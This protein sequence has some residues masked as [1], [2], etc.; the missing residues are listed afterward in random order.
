MSTLQILIKGWRY[1]GEA[2]PGKTDFPLYITEHTDNTLYSSHQS[3]LCPHP[4]HHWYWG[5]QRCFDWLLPP[6]GYCAGYWSGEVEAPKRMFKVCEKTKKVSQGT[7]SP[8][9]QLT[10]MGVTLTTNW[11]LF[12][13]FL[14][15]SCSFMDFDGMYNNTQWHPMNESAWTVPFFLVSISPLCLSVIKSCRSL[16][17]FDRQLEFKYSTMY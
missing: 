6:P 7:Q 1:C 13:C 11:H 10:G 15:L 9:S 2:L 16:S 8:A 3:S 17:L 5:K 12:L 14:G 4:N